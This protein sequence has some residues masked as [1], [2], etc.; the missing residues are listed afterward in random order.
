VS[1][2]P[3]TILNQRYRIDAL[4]G[5][6]GFGAVYRAEDTNLQKAC[7]VK[8]NLD[9][10]E[11]AQRQFGRE[12][13]ILANINH[14]NLPRVTDHFSLSGQ[15]Q[16]LVMD[17]VDGEDLATRLANRRGAL[18]ETDVLDWITQVCDALIYLHSQTPPIIHRDIKP[19]NIRITPAGQ[20]MLVDFGIAKIYNST[21][22][23]TIGARAITPGFSPFEQYGSGTTDARTDIYALGATAYALLTGQDP[24]ESI[25]RMAGTAIPAPHKYNP[26]LHPET[27]RAIM[28]ALEVLPEKRFRSVA[29]FKAALGMRVA[30]A[31]I[32]PIQAPMQAVRL[33]AKPIAPPSKPR[34]GQQTPVNQSTP[35]YPPSQ[36]IGTTGTMPVPGS[37]P[38]KH[39]SWLTIGLIAGGLVLCCVVGVGG[40]AGM[41]LVNWASIFGGSQPT[42]IAQLPTA[43]M[44]QPPPVTVVPPITEPTLIPTSPP[45]T[46]PAPSSGAITIWEV[47][48]FN[49]DV[50]NWYVYGLLRNDT[51][52][53]INNVMVQVQL[54]DSSGIVLFTGNAYVGIYNLLPGETAPFAMYSSQ[55]VSG[56][57][58]TLATVTS[59]ETTTINRAQVDFQGITLLADNYNDIY[60]S[61]EVVNNTSSPISVKSIAAGIFNESNTLVTANQAYPWVSYLAPG[62]TVPFTVLMDAPIGQA[63]SMLSNYTLY[64]DAQYTDARIPYDLQIS[65][66]FDFQDS[67][68]N[69]HLSGELTN[70]SN[71]YLTINL[72]AGIY[73]A[74]G[75]VLDTSS[76]FNPV[77]IPPGGSIPYEFGV[78]GALNYATGT[79]ERA[80]QYLV[81]IDWDFVF[82]NSPSYYLSIPTN[83]NPY[84]GNGVNISGSLTNDSGYS[85]N[86]VTVYIGISDNTTR[87]V[88]AGAFVSPTDQTLANG[89]TTTFDS[90]LFT[91]P[92]FDPAN[93]SYTLYALGY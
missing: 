70:N 64:S 1:L 3:G 48:Q 38:R 26:Q 30:P 50:N 28:H 90:Y 7:A 75:N 61:G 16:Y 27:E 74:N 87:Q 44:T 10:S 58:S 17:F 76:F 31:S 24:P 34:A 42:P 60:L 78:W 83:E 46:T 72:I 63:G 88:V 8:E 67:N 69:F 84:D 89:E 82:T 80:T 32:S 12:A 52:A 51:T 36:P 22:K 56:V 29:E 54:F 86:N 81:F 6:G 37:A 21:L 14:P 43:T 2:N 91:P 23:T 55:A 25:A 40:T 5:Q 39:P 11:A 9:S 18:S 53:G 45:T 13:S 93:Y 68:N 66:Q 71:E 65:D 73:D 47:N 77:A 85:L 49:D 92:G 62:D 57:N 20:A 33:P 4:L 35:S 79:Y 41:G 59:Y 15:G 19:A